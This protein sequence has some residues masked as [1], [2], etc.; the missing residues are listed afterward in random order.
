MWAQYGTLFITVYF[1]IYFATFG[2]AY[3]LVSYGIIP[4]PDPET[5]NDS[6]NGGWIQRVFSPHER[7]EVSPDAAK[8]VTSFLIVASTKPVRGAV[9]VGLVPLLVRLLR[10]TPKSLP[11]K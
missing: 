10:I 5:I 1:S 7:I 9:S 11:G 6:L 4:Q 2:G 8:F 3:A